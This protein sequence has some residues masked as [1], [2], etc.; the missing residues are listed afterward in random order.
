MKLVKWLKKEVVETQ[1]LFRSVPGLTLALYILSTVMMNLL[2]SVALINE[3]W[4]AL[5]AGIIVAFVGFILNDMIVKRFG[6]KA[7]IKVTVLGFVV[8]LLTASVFTIVAVIANAG[9]QYFA[10][11]DYATLTQWWIIG[12]SA[13][14][15][16]VSG[17]IDAGVHR[18]ILK[19][20]KSKPDGF[21]AHAASALGS[22]FVG[23]VIDNMLF[24]LLFTFPA[25]MIGLWGMTPMTFLA[26]VGFAVTGGIVELV[27]QALFTPLGF[28]IAESWR[29]NKVGQEYLDLINKR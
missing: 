28:K 15:F 17:I 21:G 3:S 12:A 2:A 11:G 16:L 23:Q 20:F 13:M 19:A 25:S 5:D 10:L 14:A 24:G 18:L 7:A 27:C 9:G 29:A 1:V 26:L 6:A 8:N 22:T 4:I